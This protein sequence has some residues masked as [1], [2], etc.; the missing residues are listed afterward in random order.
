MAV[1][2]AIVIVMFIINAFMVYAIV[3]TWERVGE[4]VEKYFL[5]K[6]AN[7]V[8]TEGSRQEAKVEQTG[9]DSPEKAVE[10]REIFLSDQSIDRS[11][12]KNADFK[13]DYKAVKENMDFSKQDIIR[14]VISGEEE[15]DE[16]SAVVELVRDFDFET[17]YQLSTLQSDEQK[18]VL[19]AS[20]SEGQLDILNEYLSSKVEAFSCI[21]FFDYVTQL[22]KRQDPNFYVKTGWSNDSFEHLGDNVVTVH[23]RDITEGLKI[24]HK[25]KLYDYSI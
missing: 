3:R 10:T 22:A 8:K 25:D 1:S 2:I 7:F 12:Y 17:I 24:V 21:D 23:D 18:E 16:T 20:L 6:T 4:K 5:V 14:D 11:C 9:F 19:K 13:E 15:S